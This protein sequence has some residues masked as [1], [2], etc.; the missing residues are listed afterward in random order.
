MVSG[1]GSSLVSGSRSVTR[2]PTKQNIAII[3][4]GIQAI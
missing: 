2:A 4:E 1:R 3:K